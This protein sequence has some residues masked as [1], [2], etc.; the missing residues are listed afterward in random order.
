MTALS[1]PS[2]RWG[3]W[4][5]L[6]LASLLLPGC[7]RGQEEKTAVEGG[8][9][10]LPAPGAPPPLTP[11]HRRMLAL[12]QEIEDRTADEHIYLGDRRARQLREELAHLDEQASPRKRSEL[13]FAAGQAEVKL[14]NLE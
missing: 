1:F 13:H 10:P 14:G 7:G 2:P 6:L 9:A 11:G 12:L 4:R 5:S 3:W 8:P